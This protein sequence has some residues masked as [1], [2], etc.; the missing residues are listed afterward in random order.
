MAVFFP[1]EVGFLVRGDSDITRLE[2][3][4]GKRVAGGFPRQQALLKMMEASLATAGLSLDDVTQVPVPDG[5]RGLDELAAGNVDAAIFSV[6]SGRVAQTDASVRDGVRFLPI[7][8]GEDSVAAMQA[9]APSSYVRTAE[10]G[11]SRAGI[12]EPT[13]VLASS[14]LLAGHASLDDE[15]VSQ[16]LQ[17]LVDEHESISR[18]HGAFREFIPDAIYRDLGIPYHPAALEFFRAQGLIE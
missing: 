14:M 15:R 18:V 13:P 17:M 3:L 10:P 8:T 4:R 7:E 16:I 2:D 12:E 6:G 5:G 11:Q 1:L 9:I